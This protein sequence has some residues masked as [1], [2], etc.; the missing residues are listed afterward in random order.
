MK[1]SSNR[2]EKAS[3][4]ELLTLVLANAKAAARASTTAHDKAQLAKAK[5]KAAR[6]AYKHA[7]KAA[8]KAA[9]FAKSAQAKV[10]EL[11]AATKHKKGKVVPTPAVAATDSPAKTSK[12]PA[13]AVLSPPS[14]PVVQ[15]ALAPTAP[16]QAQA[17]PAKDVTR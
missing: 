17:K 4:K 13:A 5:Y 16:E 2:I 14:S 3:A 7:K 1:Q 10:L 6:K 9:K 11:K 12:A 8:K 15:L